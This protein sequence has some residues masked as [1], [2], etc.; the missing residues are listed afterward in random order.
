MLEA[1]RSRTVPNFLVARASAN[2]LIKQ[3]VDLVIR[4]SQKWEFLPRVFATIA[5]EL[6]D[7]AHYWADLGLMPR[8][9]AHFLQASLWDLYAQLLSRDTDSKAL[10]Y[11]RCRQNYMHATGHFDFPARHVD[12]AFQSGSMKGYLRTPGT[13]AEGP[14]PCVILVNSVNSVKEEL[15]FAENAFLKMGIAT[16]SFDLPGF[17]ESQ[18]DAL[19]SSDFEILGN[20]LY[21]FLEHEPAIDANR[22]ALH[23]LGVGGSLALS[24]AL[25]SP[26]RYKAVST[27][28]APLHLAETL[29]RIIP[30]VRREAECLT[31]GAEEIL[32]DFAG[33]IVREADL[34]YILCPLLVAG[35]GRDVL[36]PAE[37]TQSIYEQAGSTDKKL[38][39]I[40]KAGHGCY[41]MMPSLRYEIA[42]WICQRI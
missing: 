12:I 6:S 22:L 13:E 19:D 16:L 36:V 29:T 5:G 27:L 20:T 28:S 18:D 11:A 4:Q 1:L 25:I 40:P 34:R 35:G 15:H 24:L 17:G 2:G 30:A 38:L 23:G 41:E 3:E 10:L 37:D 8:A 31:G 26:D 42:Q 32:R 14:Y 33:R 7:K 9:S 21:L 39:Y